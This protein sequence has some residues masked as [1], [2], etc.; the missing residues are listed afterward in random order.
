VII[1]G[2]AENGS[3]YETIPASITIAAGDASVAVVVRPLL[4]S[5]GEA[6]ESVILTVGNAP[7]YVV[8]SAASATV[9]I[10]DLAA[11][12][13]VSSPPPAPIAGHNFAWIINVTNDGPGPA[14]GV[15]L[16]LQLPAG[17]SF[18]SSSPAGTPHSETLVLEL[19]AL[20]DGTAKVARVI[21]H[22][23][24]AGTPLN[25][26]ANT[27]GNESDPDETNNTVTF[28]SVTERK[29]TA[30]YSGFVNPDAAFSA[31]GAFT[32]HVTPGA[33]FTARFVIAGRAFRFAGQ[34]T[35]GG[36]FTKTLQISGLG[37]VTLTLEELDSNEAVGTI[38]FGGQTFAIQA[39][40]LATTRAAKEAGRYTVLME[41][42][43][44]A[45][46]LPTGIG[47]ATM[48]VS[49]AGNVRISGELGDGRPFAIGSSLTRSSTVPLFLQLYNSRGFIAGEISFRDIAGSSD[50]DG[51]LRWL[52]P[53]VR[54]RSPFD[55]KV[56]FAATRYVPAAQGEYILPGLEALNGEAVA[57]FSGGSG[58]DFDIAIHIP[59]T[60]R[61]AAIETG[62]AQFTMSIIPATGWFSGNL[63]SPN[64]AL[65]RF[66]G[67]FLKKANRGGGRFSLRGEIGA[68]TIAPE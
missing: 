28:A 67:A 30:L 60:G 34:F 54:S 64:S 66:R 56:L 44:A 37:S 5:F 1:S 18:V 26:G 58:D 8:G 50:A 14:H 29:T 25:F 32:L 52:K 16:R 3:D 59:V 10:S 63:S 4:D 55:I 43:E 65:I 7:T 31:T 51:E 46:E 57:A 48:I 53:T 39:Q 41:P 24:A 11:D 49:K 45:G 2:T 27:I 62:A 13:A 23:A 19:G 9:N 17:A 20:A 35:A 68:V 38:S 42:G 36:T 33:A 22:A 6:A 21:L 61:V 47:F 12:L 40:R 15:E